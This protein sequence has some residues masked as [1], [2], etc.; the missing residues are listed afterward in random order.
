MDAK[1]VHVEEGRMCSACAHEV[2]VQHEHGLGG[3]HYTYE[4]SHPKAV[5]LNFG[6]IRTSGVTRIRPCPFYKDAVP[7]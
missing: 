7:F 2:Y 6:G 1:E 5:L 3:F 4:C